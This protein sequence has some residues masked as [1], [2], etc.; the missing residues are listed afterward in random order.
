MTFQVIDLNTASKRHLMT[1]YWLQVKAMGLAVNIQKFALWQCEWPDP[2][3]PVTVCIDGFPQIVDATRLVPWDVL[4]TSLREWSFEP[5]TD[6]KHCWSLKDSELTC[7][8]QW[9]LQ[10][11]A[12]PT[13]IV[14]EA[15]MAAGWRA[16]PKDEAPEN[17][18]SGAQLLFALRDFVHWKSYCQCLFSL[19]TRF[20]EGP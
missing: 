20:S 6:L 10:G 9:D 19:E 12:T 13:L 16:A 7:E 11:S 5:S 8:R 4:R 17:H 15:L 2:N 1:E 3:T 14:L 18:K